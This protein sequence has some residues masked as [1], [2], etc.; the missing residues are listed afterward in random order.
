MK[1]DTDPIEN[2]RIYRSDHLTWVIG[3]LSSTEGAILGGTSSTTIIQ[4]QLT[5]RSTNKSA[6]YVIASAIEYMEK[7]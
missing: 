3:R 2:D 7:Q 1:S 5:I 4:M 6:V